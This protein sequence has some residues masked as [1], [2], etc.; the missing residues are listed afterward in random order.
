MLQQ[1]MSECNNYFAIKREA[2]TF[3]I[4]DN[5]LYLDSKCVKGQYVLIQG[6][7]MNDG[8]YKVLEVGENYIVLNGLTDEA[9]N[10]Y[11][12]L[13]AIP[14]SFQQLAIEI[15][16]FSLKNKST[17]I[18]SESFGNYSKSVAT[19]KD[20]NVQSWQGVFKKQLNK[21]KKIYSDLES[22]NRRGY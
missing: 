11:L 13:L 18:V 21:Y 10:G 7:V 9:F 17:V 22:F 3:K 15:E 8:V 14:R 4:E 19:D 1:I 12:Y 5:K 16:E 20:G 6:S 2:R